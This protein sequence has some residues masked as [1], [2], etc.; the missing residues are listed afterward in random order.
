[1]VGFIF[2]RN[3]VFLAA[4][5]SAKCEENLER[6]PPSPPHHPNPVP[7]KNPNASSIASS[8]ITGQKEDLSRSIGEN[9]FDQLDSHHKIA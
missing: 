7:A 6:L 3:D 9:A 2:C 5:T 8:G 1:M 4:T